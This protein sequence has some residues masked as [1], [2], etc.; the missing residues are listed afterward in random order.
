MN[1]SVLIGESDVQ[2]NGHIDDDIK[3]MTDEICFLKSK[4]L[5]IPIF[6]VEIY[7]TSIIFSIQTPPHFSTSMK[8]SV[9]GESK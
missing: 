9:K 1:E 5:C 7:V 4:L 6:L 2:D 3:A 8:T